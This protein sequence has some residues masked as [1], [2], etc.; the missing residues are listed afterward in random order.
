[1]DA[2]REE[3]SPRGGQVLT[4]GNLRSVLLERMTRSLGRDPHTAS[5]RDFYDALSLAL[6]RN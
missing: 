4:V 1:M 2:L 5:P 3:S 6:R